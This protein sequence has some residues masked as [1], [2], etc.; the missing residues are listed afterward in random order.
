MARA[1]ESE[2]SLMNT[3]RLYL[4]K[5]KPANQFQAFLRKNKLRTFKRAVIVEPSQLLKVTE[6]CHFY[7]G[8]M[9]DYQVHYIK[10]LDSG[11]STRSDLRKSF[12]KIFRFAVY[13]EVLKHVALCCRIC[14][15]VMG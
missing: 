9:E 11:H 2:T 8:F 15:A 10:Y 7:T 14:R 13:P 3:M 12:Y 6:L 5:T 1:L 4:F